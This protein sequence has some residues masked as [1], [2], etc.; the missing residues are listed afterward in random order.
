[1]TY[2]N[3]H[4]IILYSC[5]TETV[6]IEDARP[7]DRHGQ[8]VNIIASDAPIYAGTITDD[9]RLLIGGGARRSVEEILVE[10]GYDVRSFVAQLGT[11]AAT[12]R[13]ALRI[14]CQQYVD[15]S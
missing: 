8:P 5:H 1:M 12:A 3:E 11:D 15:A 6:T 9:G 14:A 2:D 4:V 7:A 13:E 10:A